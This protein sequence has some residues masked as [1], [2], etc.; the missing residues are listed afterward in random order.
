MKRPSARVAAKA[1]L[2]APVLV[3]VPNIE[4]IEVGENWACSTGVFTF[5]T[6]DL[7]SAIASQVDPFVRTPVV[8][9]GH[10][11]PRF[12]GQPSLGRVMNLHVSENKQTLLGDYVGVPRWLAECMASAFPRRS[13]EGWF[14]MTSRANNEWPFVLEGVALLGDAYPAI[15]CLEDVQALY[16]GTP[17]IFVPLEDNDHIIARTEGGPEI[18]IPVS[19]GYRVAASRAPEHVMADASIDDVVN[20]FYHGPASDPEMYWWWIREVRV[21]P[22][23]IIVDDDAGNLFRVPYNLKSSKDGTD[24]VSF[25]ESQQVRIQYVDVVAAGQSIVKRFGNPVAASRPRVRDAVSATLPPTNQKGSDMQPS[26]EVLLALGLAPEATEEEVN[27]A[28]L[29]KLTPVAPPTVVEAPPVVTGLNGPT[30]APIIPITPATPVI[31]EGMA[32]IDEQT[33]TELRE[34]VAA[35]NSLLRER[36]NQI[37]ASVLDGAIK[38]GK[39]PPARRE[40]YEA[41]FKADPEGTTSLLGALQ[42]GLIP[43]K[44]RGHEG[45]AEVAASNTETAYPAAWNVS[46]KAAQRHSMSRVKVAGDN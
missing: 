6:A 19:T 26:A 29:A 46:V 23:E 34:G 42:P 2:D 13:I 8:K 25:G 3:T 27:A 45:S 15:N 7:Q 17:P 5:T 24:A 28:M 41:M 12:D 37:R 43:V 16:G 33:L 31:P 11:D 20:A 44:E 39:I 18:M 9:L 10:T 4:L 32:L 14:G 36:D 38:A 30:D 35:S 22:M 21:D 40:H 1:A